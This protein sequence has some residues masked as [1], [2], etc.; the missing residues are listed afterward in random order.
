V[1]KARVFA[2]PTAGYRRDELDELCDLIEEVESGRNDDTGV[3][4][5][6]RTYLIRLLGVRPKRRRRSIQREAIEEGWSVAQL[7][8]EIAKRFG[9]RRAGG[10]RPAAAGSVADWLAQAERLC[11]AWRR[12]ERRLDAG[13]P[14]QVIRAAL[15]ARLRAPLRDATAGVLAL[16]RVVLAELGR[17]HPEREPRGGVADDRAAGTQ[18]KPKGH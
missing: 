4:V 3:S 12:W 1:R 8:A 16:H 18:T 15:P 9:P 11:E 5:F 6:G 13:D 14:D 17:R 2:D 10:R 7:E